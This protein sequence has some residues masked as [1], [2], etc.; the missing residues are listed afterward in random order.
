MIKLNLQYYKFGYN[1]PE[2]RYRKTILP[3]SSSTFP[4]RRRLC[5]APHQLPYLKS[6]LDTRFIALEN[7]SDKRFILATS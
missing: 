3:E 5:R 1:P 4:P 2:I 7:Y 6:V